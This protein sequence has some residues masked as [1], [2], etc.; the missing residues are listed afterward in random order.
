MGYTRFVIIGQERTGSVFLQMLLANHANVLSL[1]EIFNPTEET[2][3]ASTNTA[4]PI[5]LD[6]DPIEYLENYVYRDHPGHIKAV[7]FRLFYTHARNIEWKEVWTYLGDSGVKIIHLKRKNLL[8]RYLSHQLALRLNKWVAYQGEK[9]TT[10]QP[11]TL[12]PTDCFKD[13][14]KTVWYQEKIDDLFKDNPTIE[15]TYEDLCN[16]TD[17][18]CR[19]IQDFLELDFQELSA[20]TRR[21]RTQKK[22]ELVTSYGELRKQLVVGVSKGWAREEWLDFFDEE[23]CQ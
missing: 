10:Y 6:D 13:F 21:Q 3:K 20:K 9:P 17:Q 23:H 1:G 2:R 8:D 16:D 7:G 19:R 11:I 15:V 4:G 18:E 22:S 5:G 12:D 14:H